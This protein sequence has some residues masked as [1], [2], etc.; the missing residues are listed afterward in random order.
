MD[1][2]P[3]T[4]LVV[5]DEKNIRR[6]LR[7]IL[8]GEGYAVSEAESAEQAL[9]VLQAEPT[10]L[11]IF[12]IR[13]PGMLYARILRPPAHGAERQSLDTS[14]AAALPGVQVIDD[15][16]LVAV[17]AEAPDLAER[18]LGRIK[19]TWKPVPAQPA[20]VVGRELTTGLGEGGYQ[21]RYGASFVMAVELT[22]TGP[23]GVGLLAYGQTSDPSSP[24]FVAGTE[25]FAVGAVRPLLF[26]AH[27]GDGVIGN[28]LRPERR[29]SD[30]HK[31]SDRIGM[32]DEHRIALV[33]RN[34]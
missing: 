2:G 11:G 16:D 17:L 3:S 8:E 12:D 13:L 1:P 9:E 32:I 22:E 15:G 19:A 4:V 7:M 6:T 18:A 5:D 27:G 21:L 23:V 25:A 34:F 24:A 26:A 28:V 31:S 29:G 30:A 14:G 20:P 33:P 10:D